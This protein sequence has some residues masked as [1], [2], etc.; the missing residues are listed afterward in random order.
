MAKYGVIDIGS[1]SVRLMMSSNGET[2]YKKVKIT[3]LAEGLLESSI[4]SD[5]AIERTATAVK[6]F[7]VHAVNSGADKVMAFATAAVRSAENGYS[8]TKRVKEICGLT[9]EVISGETEAR[10]GYLGALNGKDGGVID[11]GGASSEITVVKSGKSVYSFSLNMGSVKIA[12][13]CGQDK[14]RVDVFLTEKIKEYGV[15]PNA[16]FYAIG[17]TATTVSAIM[18]ELEIYD[19]NKVEGYKIEIKP[20]KDLCDKLFSLTV[21][22]RKKLKG[23]QP[24]R[25]EVIAGGAMLLLKIME[26]LSI[27]YL[28]VSERDNLEGYLTE[29]NL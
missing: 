26:K 14:E 2:L 23:L 11:I 1:N 18:Q 27:G 9:V 28:T 21:E 5:K 10:I 15:I 12:D 29:K 3:K 13:A 16:E 24:E 7:Y 4:L 19:P 22:E 8:F 25:A 20:L 6:D 17:G